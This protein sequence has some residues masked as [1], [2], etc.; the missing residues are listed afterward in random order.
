MLKKFL[1]IVSVFL[2]VFGFSSSISAKSKIPLKPTPTATP[3]PA[4]VDSFSL[5]W[6]VAAGRTMQSRVYFLKTLKEDIRG[7]FIFGS[8]QKAN[9]SVFLGTKRLLEAE[10]L[11]KGSIQDEANKQ[12]LSAYADKTLESAFV[13]FNNASESIN[14]AK[15]S[16]NIDQN[17]K[18]EI[19]SR[20][21]NLKLFVNSLMTGYHDYNGKLQEVSAS[22]N[23]ISL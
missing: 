13:D 15:N 1:V 3:T 11:M 20:I 10:V 17:T 22:L 6:P 18:D 23:S 19:N 4:P 16:G 21:S 9:Y 5:F 2:F 14:S 8:A 12:S 7:I